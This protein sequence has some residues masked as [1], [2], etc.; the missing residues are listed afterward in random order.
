M[1]NNLQAINDEPDTETRLFLF[2]LQ[3]KNQEGLAIIEQQV[4][5]LTE[6]IQ[7]L[8]GE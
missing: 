1:A 3:Q 8:G 5:N 6:Q 2:E 7:H 4:R